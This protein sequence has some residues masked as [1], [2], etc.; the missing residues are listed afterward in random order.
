MFNITNAFL[1]YYISNV[2][3]NLLYFIL[4]KIFMLSDEKIISILEL[5]YKLIFERNYYP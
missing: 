4:A 3:I 2:S 1:I 5:F